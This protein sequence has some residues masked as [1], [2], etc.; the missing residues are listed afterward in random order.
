MKLSK[1]FCWH[2]SKGLFW[3]RVFGKGIYFKNKKTGTLLFSERNGLRGF[4]IGNT[5]IQTLK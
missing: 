3:F 4:S 1:I 5:F 2:K